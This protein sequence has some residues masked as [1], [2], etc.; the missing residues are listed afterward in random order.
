MAPPPA[1]AQ[2]WHCWA[3]AS[4]PKDVSAFSPWLCSTSG[5]FVRVELTCTQTADVDGTERKVLT[6]KWASDRSGDW[7][8]ERCAGERGLS[9]CWRD[10]KWCTQT[11]WTTAFVGNVYAVA[12]NPMGGNSPDWAHGEEQWEKRALLYRS[13]AGLPHFAC[14]SCHRKPLAFQ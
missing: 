5:F 11:E 13:D 7:S 14:K 1:V 9:S 10:L 8:S 6:H 12:L 4:P 3:V 2:E